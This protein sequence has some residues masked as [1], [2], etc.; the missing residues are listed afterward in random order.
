VANSRLVGFVGFLL[1][2]FWTLDLPRNLFAEENNSPMIMPLPAHVVRGE[3]EFLID[4]GF[5]IGLKGYREPRLE[6]ARQ[7]FL[8]TLSQETGIPL[9]REAILNPPTS[10]FKL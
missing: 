3:G 2:G 9:W 7:R 1:L 10:S 8:D 6:R 5:G 4:G